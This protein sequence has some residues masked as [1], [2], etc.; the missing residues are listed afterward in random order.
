MIQSLQCSKDDI[1]IRTGFAYFCKV[2]LN[3]TVQ[4]IQQ[5]GFIVKRVQVLNWHAAHTFHQLKTFDTSW[6]ENYAKEDS[7]LLQFPED[8]SL[9]SK[10]GG[11]LHNNKHDIFPAFIETWDVAAIKHKVN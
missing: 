2:M 4:L 10:E 9:L 6:N 5:H 7:G 8:Y 1:I 3:R 11:M